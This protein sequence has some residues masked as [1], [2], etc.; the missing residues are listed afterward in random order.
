MKNNIPQPVIFG[1]IGLVLFA[2]A[3]FAILI[4][5]NNNP[6]AN[7][8]I[9]GDD[10]I[11][12]ITV[13]YPE[14]GYIA[15]S[16]NENAAREYLA[17]SGIVGESYI[18]NSEIARSV[19]DED[20]SS[21]SSEHN[22]QVPASHYFFQQYID[23]VAVQ[24]SI[25]GVHV[26]NNNE[27][28][29]VSGNALVTFDVESENITV[30]EAVSKAVD[31][32]KKEVGETVDME[33]STAEKVIYNSKLI[34]LS[35]DNRNIPTVKVTVST[36]ANS[37]NFAKEY[38]ISLIDGEKLEERTLIFHALNRTIF[39]CGGSQ[40]SCSQVRSEGAP[41]YGARDIDDGYNYFGDTYNFYFN[42]Y[43]RDSYDGNG[44]Q[45]R[46][47]MNYYTGSPNAGWDSKAGRMIYSSNMVTPD[48]TGHELTHAVTSST[49]GLIYNAQSGAINEGMSDVFGWA[50][51]PNDWT[52]GEGSALG[53]IRSLSNP[54]SHNQPDR[55]F[56]SNYWCS[57]ADNYGVHQNSGI[58]NKTFYLLVEGGSFNT[59]NVSSIGK[60]RALAIFY[61]ALTRYLTPS[62][63]LKNLYDSLLQ[64]CNDLYAG[65]AGVCEQVDIASQATEID[66]QPAG[67]QSGPVCSGNSGQPPKCSGNQGGTIPTSVPNQ[68]TLTPTSGAQVRYYIS[69]R[70]YQDNNGNTQYDTS[71]T[72][73][74]N[75]SVGLSGSFTDTVSTLSDGTFIF[76]NLF[77]GTFNVSYD[78]S[79]RNDISLSQ[80]QSA[81]SVNFIVTKDP[82]NPTPTIVAGPTSVPTTPTPAA[83][84][85]TPVS[86]TTIPTPT[87]PILYTCEYDPKCATGKKN[88]QLCPLVCTEKFGDGGGGRGG[89]SIPPAPTSTPGGG[90]VPTSTPQP[91]QVATSTPI[92]GNGQGAPLDVGSLVNDVSESN[93]RNYMQSLVDDDDIAGDDQSQT[94]YTST[95]GNQ[96]EANYIYNTL[97]G[98]GLNV[99]YQQFNFSG[100][101]TRNIIGKVPGKDANRV[102][103]VTAHMDSTSGSTDPAPGADDN[104]SG[105][106][107]VMEAARVLKTMQD[108]L[109]VSLEFILF[110]GEEQGL[111]GSSYYAGNIPSGKKIEGVIN[112][113]MIGNDSGSACVNFGYKNY[114]GGD[115][116]SNKIIEMIQKYNINLGGSS[117]STSNARSDH[118]PFWSRGIPAI[119]G[120][121]CTFSSVY[122]STNDK[123][124]FINFAQITN[125]AKGVVA[126]V[127]ELSTQ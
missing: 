112:L 105:T 100:N 108:K 72:P 32:A 117:V 12:E 46:G 85:P 115:I 118:A 66:Q 52:L 125:T 79:A 95:N 37:L 127:A 65:D 23:G 25:L 31:E 35:S 102:Y 94:R 4:S 36:E 57:S 93:I 89:S 113:D 51:D 80:T 107:A 84:T 98:F 6:K 61:R 10:T 122:H 81:V 8:S 86:A 123:I 21:S 26:R 75:Q 13:K 45:L 16:T 55:L 34:G 29:Y 111:Y 40:T 67:S 49:A 1:I 50:V 28:Y 59:C 41:P 19:E 83:S 7:V 54:P 58:I 106:V 71:D 22:I 60:D 47:Y 70:I 99:E 78:S 96:T 69:G 38:F 97:Q 110:S 121:E 17:E 88:I 109:N 20:D 24:D 39:D 120:H 101:T 77:N 73:L 104:A 11:R 27:V 62:S 64:S 90:S 53:V 91:G 82:L 92:T 114:N 124:E 87:T 63:N 30:E 2:I 74:S 9:S 56:A 5:L 42:N 68:P 126:A 116:M 43:Q 14:S 48:I 76:D 44:A 18:D 103:L 119:F 15:R 3:F 33:L